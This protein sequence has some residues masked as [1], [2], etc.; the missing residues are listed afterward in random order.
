MPY[1]L[2]YALIENII[3]LKLEIVTYSVL[4]TPG[5]KFT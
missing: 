1:Q 5:V 3:S 2:N 4:L